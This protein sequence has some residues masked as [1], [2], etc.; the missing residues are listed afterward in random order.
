ME[1]ENPF[2]DAYPGQ[3]AYIDSLIETAELTDLEYTDFKERLDDLWVMDAEE[4]I[5]ELLRKQRNPIL[6]GYNYQ[7]RDIIRMLKKLK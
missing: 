1:N 3:M 5:L 7:Q 6:G 2:E 4:L